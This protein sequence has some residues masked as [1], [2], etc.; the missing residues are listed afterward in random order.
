MPVNIIMPHMGESVVEGKVL[1]WLKAPGDRVAR[2]EAL[3]EVATDKINVEI[4]SSTDGVLLAISAQQGETVQIDQVLGQVGE[5]GEAV[6]EA[7]PPPPAEKKPAPPPPAEKKPAPAK[8]EPPA[9]KKPAAAPLKPA[10]PPPPAAKPPERR[11]LPPLRRPPAP[12]AQESRPRPLAGPPGRPQDRIVP[13]E[14]PIEPGTLGVLASPEVRRLA[15]EWLVN[16]GQVAGTGRMGRI[17]REDVTAFIE[18]HR[19]P[20]APKPA[21]PPEDAIAVKPPV[22]GDAVAVPAA[23]AEQHP[24]AVPGASTPAGPRPADEELVPLTPM[25]RAIAEHMVRSKAE[26]PH[27]TTVADVDMTAVAALRQTLKEKA[28]AA[29][30]HLTYT[31]FIAHAVARA[32]REYPSLN[33]S[34]TDRG[35]LLKYRINLGLAVSIEDGLVV[36]VIR[37][38]DRLTLADLARALAAVA[39]KTRQ[40][41]VAAADV[42]GGTFTITN[43][44]VFGAVL[45]T[46]IIH[47]PQV[48]ILATGR[49]ADAPA[50]VNGGFFIRK[51]MYLSLSYDHRVV[52]GAAAVRF[53]Q[54]VRQILEAADFGEVEV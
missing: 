11:A 44:G 38:A 25:R 37:D 8:E 18:A 7:A 36:P 43:P 19:H 49:V 51:H 40:G 12:A 27:V 2:D 54:R 28:D 34:W 30:L 16:L 33:A 21:T 5:A 45:S 32:L 39:E 48:A 3:V 13:T 22:R 42:G 9:E 52:D 1:R 6:A 41:K 10:A 53:L 26:A 50:V 4:P 15:R 35:I 14:G 17:T 29:G 20:A 46:P 31:A 47:Q 24:V 23:P